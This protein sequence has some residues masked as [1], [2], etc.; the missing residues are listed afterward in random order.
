MP[1]TPPEEECAKSGGKAAK[2]DEATTSDPL[3]NMK[4]LRSS[5]ILFVPPARHSRGLQVATGEK[6]KSHPTAFEQQL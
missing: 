1:V 6:R 5:I 4:L 2:A 3:T